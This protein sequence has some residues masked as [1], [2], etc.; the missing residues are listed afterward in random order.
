MSK[1]KASISNLSLLIAGLLLTTMII[2]CGKQSSNSPLGLNIQY[3]VLNLSPDLFPVNLFV[4]AQSVNAIN[5][6][7]VYNINHGYFYVPAIDTPY[8]FRT[9]L[10][11]GATLFSRDDILK[12][13]LKYTLFII[14]DNKDH[15]VTQIFTVDSASAPAIGRGKLR[16]VNASPTATGGLDVTANG[17]PAFSKIPYKTVSK[18]I[19]LPIGNYDIQVKATGSSNILKDLPAV[20]IQD[21]R[22]YTLYSYGYTTRVDSA[23]FNAAVLTNK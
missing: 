20:T 17:T 10:S 7:F 4:N 12:S 14:G 23:A 18:F 5:N 3:Q 6:P 16:F 15:S 11:S 21:G 8:Q 19:E 2:S 22:L 9:A 1:H 13:G